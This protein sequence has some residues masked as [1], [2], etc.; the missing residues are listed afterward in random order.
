MLLLSTA[1]CLAPFS[2]VALAETAPSIEGSRQ[3]APRAAEPDALDDPDR[4]VLPD[5]IEQ[6]E[7]D[8]DPWVQ[9]VEEV[10]A[11]IGALES[12][13]EDADAVFVELGPVL[14]QRLELLA[15][16]IGRVDSVMHPIEVPSELSG[17]ISTLQD[18]HR[19]VHRLYA[20]RTT[21]MEF[22]S[23]DLQA[24]IT[25][26]KLF[27][28]Q[29]LRT[30]ANFA[31]QTIRYQ[32]FELPVAWDVITLRLERSPLRF[33]TDVLQLALLF[34]LFTWWRRWFPDTLASMRRSLMMVRPRSAKE[35]NRL[36]VIWYIEQVRSPVEWL[37][38]IHLL[39]I[40]IPFDALTVAKDILFIVI[41]WLLV[42]RIIVLLINAIAARGDVGLAGDEGSLRL[43]SLRLLSAWLLTLGIGLSL[44]EYLTGEGAVYAAVWRVFK[45]LSLPVAVMLLAWWKERIFDRLALETGDA[46]QF[47]A[48][49]QRRNGIRG[50]FNAASGLGHL[51][52]SEI[53]KAA[54]RRAGVDDVLMELSQSKVLDTVT[55]VPADV[56]DAEATRALRE[57]FLQ[58]AGLYPK[59]ARTERRPLVQRIN[60]G[61]SGIAIVVGE[62]GIG[63]T[64]FLASLE[65]KIESSLLYVDCQATT[66]ADFLTLI[67]HSLGLGPDAKFDPREVRSRLQ[68]KGV[69]LVAVDNIHRLVRPVIGGQSELDAAISRLQEFDFPGTWLYTIDRHTWQYILAAQ[70]KRAIADTILE[71]PPWTEEQIAEYILQRC[72]ELNIEPDFSSVS[73]P[74]QFL[75]AQ[76]TSASER[77]R[78]GVIRMLVDYAEGNISVA[79]RLFAECLVVEKPG[80][81]VGNLPC[82]ASSVELEALP[83]DSALVL[84]VIAQFGGVEPRDIQ[85][86]L[87]VS[88]AEVHAMLRLARMRGWVE[89]NDGIL[90]LDWRWRPVIVRMLG[91]QNLLS[92]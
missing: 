91:R 14:R 22:V 38:V 47:E 9:R 52:A 73:V 69:G 41:R 19:N 39:G 54:L 13:R 15:G 33:L 77:N 59:Y 58:P 35:I 65:D 45:I 74:R 4:E 26:T 44:A 1:C 32:L 49:L 11:K 80:K 70:P 62:S 61:V 29:E 42:A 16:Q 83:L 53:Q 46:G 92:R 68:E 3:P 85:A 79:V 12:S 7:T 43:R 87:R 51:V 71:L 30:E 86:A 88:P 57:V 21:L 6:V 27:G 89:D 37:V 81:V 40:L 50:M 75:D 64:R 10:T 28:A 17:F 90:E 78:A 84:R 82:L 2:T 63:K 36:K 23:P 67:C 20:L 72:E 25:G 76:H 34:F 60:S 24:E 18:L 66:A 8:Q 56:G 5:I 48:I 31:W 55:N